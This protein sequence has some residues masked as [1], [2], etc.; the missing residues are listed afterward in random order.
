MEQINIKFPDGNSKSFDKGTTT[1]DIA[2]SISPG[3]RK[4]AVAGKFNNQLVDLTRP[5]EE[6]GAIEIVTPGS[7]EA[8]E[9]LRHSTA[10]LMAQ[11]LK[12]I[13]GDVKFGVGP[14]IEGG[15]YY[16]FDMDE[17]VSSDDFEKIEKTMKQIVN[18]NYKI[19][20]KVVTR[21]EAKDF[22]K[23]DPYK[24]ELIDAIPEDENVTLYSQGEF[25]DLCRGVHVPSTS[26]IKEFKLLST[27]GA[28]WRGDSDNKMLQRIYGTAFFD[29]KDLK[30]HLEMLEERRERDH[31]R[32]GKDLELFTNN[33]LVGAGLPLWLPNGATIRREIERYIVDKEVSMGY[34]HVYTPVLANVELYKTSGH[35]DHYRDDMFP[36]M[37]LDETEEMVLRPMNCPHHMMVYNNKPHSYRELPIRIAELGTMHRYE[38]SGA[39]SGL[40]RV[41]GMTLNDSH[42]F[43]RPD[44]IKDEFKRVVHMIQDVYEDFG[45]EDYTFRL[46]YRDPEDKEKYMDDDDMWNK[47]ESMLKEA[48]DEMG[49]PYVEAIGEAA[50]YGPK[51]DVQVKTAMGKEETLSTA[52]LDFLLPERFDLSYIG[53]DGE[54]HRPVVIHRGV[55][56]TME[57][58]VAFLTEETKGAFPTWLAPKQV[59]I[60]PVNVDL[61]YDYARNLQD[62][63]KSQGV[64][65]EIDDRNEKMGYK[66]REAQMQK[67]PYQ[68]VVGDKEV[69][70]NEVNVRKY[71]SQDQETIERD[72]F[73]WNLV[74]EIRLKKRR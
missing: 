22:F 15:F 49:L 34:D 50:F 45:F 19:E 31:R 8:L 72:E 23:D 14:V 62:E 43:V 68:I 2:Q 10:H 73:I 4:K 46:S 48:V 29:K 61:H 26:K 39:V 3:L 58:F 63:L 70:N 42:I 59:E 64:R 20:R 35:W 11:A 38:A 69:E 74:D 60:I 67:I 57:R 32:I 28:Y 6:D 40:Q 18:E 25:T 1:E 9:V 12:R 66:I 36:P 53:S 33:Q 7:D 27:A 30:A 55:V 24:L 56:S 51:L 17:K 37:K 54:N 44:Q 5:L 13:Y 16:D 21:E 52:Q 41:R 71:G 47:A 65:V